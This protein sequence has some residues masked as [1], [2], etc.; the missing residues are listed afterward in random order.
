M[1][2]V[3]LAPPEFKADITTAMQ[4]VAKDT[5]AVM[6]NAKN[7][8]NDPNFAKLDES[9]TNVNAALRR[10]LAAV[11]AA[12]PGHQ[13]FSR[14]FE[15]VTKAA[16]LLAAGTSS[17]ANENDAFKTFNE[18][19][20][21][22]NAAAGKAAATSDADETPVIAK[23]AANALNQLMRATAD[24]AS[25]CKDAERA[26]ALR[27]EGASL[28]QSTGNMIQALQA[29]A[30]K[31]FKDTAAQAQLSDATIHVTDALARLRSLLPGQREY[32][33]S[34][35]L[36]IRAAIEIQLLFFL[37]VSLRLPSDQA[38][39]CDEA[40]VSIVSAI[41][42]LDSAALATAGG[43][44]PRPSGITLHQAEELVIK[45]LSQLST[46]GDTVADTTVNQPSAMAPAVSSMGTQVA[47]FASAAT[48]MAALSDPSV[49][50]VPLL[51]CY[52]FFICSVVFF[53]FHPS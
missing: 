20:R 43:T 50:Q 3:A 7:A 24:I 25:L 16:E 45:L 10:L 13:E 23:N 5:V 6:T 14:A 49:Q 38:G 42:Q 30:K 28:A 11:Y 26:S 22:L 17:S 8:T 12:S 40:I 4:A 18:G 34:R 53:F 19:A 39:R 48:D 51:S 44:L 33:Y 36:L 52:F 37:F 32:A 21:A 31:G 27:S 41:G 46:S 47:K 29:I 2:V 9:L 1:E 35:F 15:A